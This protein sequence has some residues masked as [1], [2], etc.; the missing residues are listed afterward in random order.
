M[1]WSFVF[2]GIKKLITCKV[3]YN[4]LNM[5]QELTLKFTSRGVTDISKKESLK[6]K[7]ESASAKK[8]AASNK[9]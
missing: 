2:Y 4:L 6:A 1:T 7:K 8:E 3:V 5:K 9:K